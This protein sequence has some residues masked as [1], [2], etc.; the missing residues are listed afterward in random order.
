MTI[1]FQPLALW[2]VA[3][4]L[5]GI[6]A[7]MPVQAQPGQLCG[8]DGSYEEPSETTRVVELPDFDIAVSIP[9][10]YRTM[11]FEDGSVQILHPDDF[12]W[13]RCLANGGSGAGGYYS[14]SIQQVAP[15]P[16]MSLQEQA[17]LLAG[18]STNPDGSRT[19]IATEVLHYQEN[20]LDGYIGWYPYAYGHSFLGTVTGSD[21]LLRVSTGCD[22]EVELESLLDLLSKIR[23]LN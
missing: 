8:T 5:I 14:E 9:E 16:T 19:P 10:N 15:D 20:G 17:T 4:L 6:A 12:E 13:L 3:N 23:P 22:C 21:R 1:K 11:K 18:Y 2:T 7:P